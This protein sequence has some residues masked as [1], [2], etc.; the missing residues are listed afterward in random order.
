VCIDRKLNNDMKIRPV[1]LIILTL[2]IGFIIGIL[3]SAQI[4]YQRLKPVRIFFS[5]ERF[6]EG[7]YNI[8]QPDEKQKQTID[9]ILSEYAR[10]NSLIMN[11]FRRKSDSLM[12]RFWKEIE[13]NLNSEQLERL[14]EFDR[15]RMEM[16]RQE[17]RNRDDSSGFRPGRMMPPGPPPPGRFDEQRYRR[18]HR[19]R[20]SVN[21][22]RI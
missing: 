3:V 5:G 15:R 22:S 4:R 2:I 20:D 14:R 8:I 17:R 7:F 1:L 13:P 6:R 16:I 10:A 9:F 19:E 21:H 11:D 12:K 18:P